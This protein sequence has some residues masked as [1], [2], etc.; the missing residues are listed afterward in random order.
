MAGYEMANGRWAKLRDL[1]A[2][3]ATAVIPSPITATGSTGWIETGDVQT[4]RAKIVIS[5]IGGTTPSYTF[6]FETSS[7][8]AVTD[9]ARIVG[10]AGAAITANGT[11]FLTVAGCDR[12][13]RLTWT[14][15]GTTPTAV[16]A[17]TAE[18]A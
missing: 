11:Q 10:A 12:F 5:A 8:A 14:V 3:L 1:T 6:K 15:T 2:A 4:I 7:D 13:V 18:T 9:A 17:V 16:A